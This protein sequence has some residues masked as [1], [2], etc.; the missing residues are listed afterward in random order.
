VSATG[1]VID[2]DSLL[3]FIPLLLG[4]GLPPEVREALVARLRKGAFLTA[5]GLAS[6][7]TTSAH[8]VPDGYWRG[9]LWGAPTVMLVEGLAA[10]G[11]HALAEEVRRRFCRLVEEQGLAEN[12]DALT[13]A[14]LRDRE[15]S[16]TA[17][18]FLLLAGQIEG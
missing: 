7:A 13:G 8:Y 10:V 16:W 3:L 15:F 11:E 5:Y 2:C 4:K 1:E 14:P 6:E 17:S 18:A 12:Y 9:P